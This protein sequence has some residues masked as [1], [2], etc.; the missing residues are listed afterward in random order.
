MDKV[1]GRPH[2][3]CNAEFE[4]LA[5][6]FQVIDRSKR[7]GEALFVVNPN[8]IIPEGKSHITPEELIIRRERQTF[9]SLATVDALLFT[10][11]T[12]VFFLDDLSDEELV[13]LWQEIRGWDDVVAT[14]RQREMWIGTFVEYCLG[15]GV[16][17]HP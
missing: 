4:R 3:H 14:Y 16:S 17:L 10:V 8:D 1:P 13:G 9:R 15:R 12:Y 2:P 6:F 5:Y 11:N 7:L